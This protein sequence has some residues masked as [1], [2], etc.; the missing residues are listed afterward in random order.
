MR[1]LTHN[2]LKCHVKDVGEGYPLKLTITKMSVKETK[3]NN[4]F[5]KG[6]LPNLEWQGVL[7]AAE[8]MGVEGLPKTLSPDLLQDESFLVAMHNLLIDVHV[9]EGVLTCP[10]SGRRFHICRGIPDMMVPENDV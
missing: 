4:D 8:A 5:I 9:E 7:T 10:E 1:L 2:S 3:P 6:L